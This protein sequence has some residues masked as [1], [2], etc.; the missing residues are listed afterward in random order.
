[1]R[2]SFE[3]VECLALLGRVE[4]CDKECNTTREIAR[5][6]GITLSKE[7]ETALITSCVSARAHSVD[8]LISLA[9]ES[10]ERCRYH[11][12]IS[13]LLKARVNC[14]EAGLSYSPTQ[15]ERVRDIVR[16]GAQD[17]PLAIFDNDYLRWVVAMGS[18]GTLDTE[19]QGIRAL[20]TIADAP[21]T[22]GQDLFLGQLHKEVRV[23]FITQRVLDL[24]QVLK[25]NQVPALYL[26]TPALYFVDV[27]SGVEQRAR[28]AGITLSEHQRGVI[29]Q[30]RLR[31]A[32]LKT[33]L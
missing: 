33:S 19:V 8:R 22:R 29:R 1:M 6:T 11:D 10:Q 25:S 27:A 21:L 16:R 23:A 24:E 32:Q 28:E 15:E 7:E 4:A 9:E 2:E 30:A 12:V 20:A 31:A 14:E 5:R 3:R 18:V 17:L 13:F 26:E